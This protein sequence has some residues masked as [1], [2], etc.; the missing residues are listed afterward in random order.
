MKQMVRLFIALIIMG[1][2]TNC[3]NPYYDQATKSDIEGFGK[4]YLYVAQYPVAGM[5]YECGYL[6]RNKT[7]SV[8]GFLY[9]NG[10][11]CRFF[12][13]GRE[14]FSLNNNELQDGDI[15]EITNEDMI[16]RLYEADLNTDANKI[17]LSN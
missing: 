5:E 3:N 14:F 11:S 1:F 13:N 7:D 9:E 15:Y 6:D 8:G 10:T 16:D 4:T 17:V 2:L 12:L